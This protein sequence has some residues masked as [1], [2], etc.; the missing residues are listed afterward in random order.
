MKK[1]EGIPQAVLDKFL[2]NIKS[3]EEV[4]E[5]DGFELSMWKSELRK[6]LPPLWE[7]LLESEL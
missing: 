6:E 5:I 7:S 4:E 1:N 2:K 3:E